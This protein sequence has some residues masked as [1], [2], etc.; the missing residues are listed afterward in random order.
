MKKVL[1]ILAMLVFPILIFAQSQITTPDGKNWNHTGNNAFT[2][3]ITVQTRTLTGAKID[4]YDGLVVDA[5]DTTAATDLMVLIKDSTNVITGSYVTRYDFKNEAVQKTS[6][7]KAMKAWG[8]PAYK[9]EPIGSGTYNGG[10]AMTSGTMYFTALDPIVDTTVLSTVDMWMNTSGSYTA[11]NTNGIALYKVSGSDVV[12]VAE[13]ANTGTMWTTANTATISLNF[14]APYTAL[15]GEL[16][17]SAI[18]YS[19][20]AQTTAPTPVD[21]YS[22]SSAYSNFALDAT[23]AKKMAMVVGGQSGFATS[24]ALSG[25]S[26]TTPMRGTKIR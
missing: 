2:K 9:L 16:L 6:V 22:T 10:S 13:T 11:N 24:Y 25:L 7:N 26:R 4:Q 17:Y 18:L 8:S 23:G 15:P 21:A 1:I 5:G 12:K 19:S 20:S 3:A 14:T